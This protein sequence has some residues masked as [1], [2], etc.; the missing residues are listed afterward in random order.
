MSTL[1]WDPLTCIK[2]RIFAC[3]SIC[4]ARKE[5]GKQF[6]SELPKWQKDQNCRMKSSN[7]NSTTEIVL[8]FRSISRTSINPLHGMGISETSVDSAEFMLALH[9]PWRLNQWPWA[10]S[11][12]VSNLSTLWEDKMWNGEWCYLPGV[13]IGN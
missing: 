12:S 3:S 9:V 2:C 6:I 4:R 10:S 7:Y 5:D 13:L 8:E 11:H 1:L